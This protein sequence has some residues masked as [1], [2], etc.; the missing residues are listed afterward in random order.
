MPDV[1][2]PATLS[3]YG[4]V[5]DVSAAKFQVRNKKNDV[6]MNFADTLLD[7]RM[8]STD[9][10]EYATGLNDENQWEES[11]IYDTLSDDDDDVDLVY[12]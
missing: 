5:F 10:N 2:R 8:F 11:Y 9:T 3:Y 12:S 7:R 1:D 6:R 4:I